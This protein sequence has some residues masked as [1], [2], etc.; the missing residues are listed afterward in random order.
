MTG[1]SMALRELA[2]K[3]AVGDYMKEPGQFVLQRLMEL[4]V[5]GR[6]GAARHECSY[7]RTSQRNGYRERALET[8]VGTLELR[9][10]KLRS[11]SYFPSFLEPR[12]ASEQA[13]VA[14][15]PGGVPEGHEHAK[16][17]QKGRLSVT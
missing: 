15:G 13:L 8:R 11:G 3:H 6:C 16:S 14:V 7:A 2:E 12:K 17:K 9:M 1:H 5:E 10:P 4:E